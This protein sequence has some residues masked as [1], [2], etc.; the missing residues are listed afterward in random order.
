M[1]SLRT[2][3]VFLCVIIGMYAHAQDHNLQQNIKSGVLGLNSIS[4]PQRH[5][6]CA[7]MSKDRQ[8]VYVSIAHGDW[9]SISEYQFVDNKW[10]KQRHVIGDPKFT[11]QDPYLT[12]D[13]NRLY[14]ITRVNGSADIAYMQRTPEGLWG[15]PVILDAPINTDANEFYTSF[16]NS[17]EIVFASDRDAK[18]R[19]DFNIYR[20]KPLV[21]GFQEPIPFPP[22]I[23]TLSY[24][25][26]PFI[27]PDNGYL[28]FSSNR[29]GGNG[30]RD[31]YISFYV[32]EKDD[33][34]VPVAL[35]NSVN[36]SSHEFCPMISND[37]K[38]L[39]YTS[40]RDIYSVDS[41]F[42]NNM[43]LNHQADSSQD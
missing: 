11:A 13:E 5:E 33:W 1:C 24:E 10:G 4:L 17:G 16:T 38:T 31:L 30:K 27:D 23:N 29:K 21:S 14:F 8:I 43:L 39:L 2:T 28:I 37:G 42:I 15:P 9:Q 6:F 22:S 34:T 36:T 32:L 12:S 7:S 26:D 40:A 3:V 19:G 20:A 35:D 18:R 41:S 25:A